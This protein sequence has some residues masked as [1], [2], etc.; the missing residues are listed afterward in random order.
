MGNIAHI[1]CC[2]FRT[3][4][5]AELSPATTSYARKRVTGWENRLLNSPDKGIIYE[6]SCLPGGKV[7]ELLLYRFFLTI[8]LMEDT[9]Q[10]LS[11]GTEKLLHPP[12]ACHYNFTQQQQQQLINHFQRV[13]KSFS[14]RY[15]AN[16]PSLLFNS[17][18]L[19]AVMK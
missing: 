17:R 18:S 5:W 15:L 12:H 19:S 14:S 7:F 4:S 11:I 9:A 16:G 2:L 8:Q 13:G 10:V 1:S 3:L 6:P